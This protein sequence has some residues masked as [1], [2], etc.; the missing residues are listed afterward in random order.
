VLVS[1]LGRPEFTGMGGMGRQ[2]S[3]GLFRRA[4]DYAPEG[5]GLQGVPIPVWSTKAFTAS[6]ETPLGQLPFEANL[7]YTPAEQ[8]QFTG[9]IQSNL[10][11]PLQDAWVFYGGQWY[12]LGAE[13]PRKTPGDKPPP[14]RI[15]SG[16]NRGGRKL[17]T[18]VTTVGQD[19][20]A[21]EANVP[22]QRSYDAT[23][24]VKA[25]LF[26]QSTDNPGQ[27]RNHSFRRLDQSWRLSSER[28][29]HRPGVTREAIL[30]ARLPRSAG[31]ADPA[32]RPSAAP[33]L[34]LG[35]LPG[36]GRTRP[37]L[38]GSLIQDTYLRVYLPVTPAQP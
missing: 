18:W 31:Q 21:P 2:R 3:Q 27:D 15:A 10:P 5:A 28:W 6:W 20:D 4:Y 19:R 16:P 37:E 1:W 22:S 32:G 35:E 29:G 30:F 26:Q 23:A 11:V 25:L 9:S 38:S 7:H 8:E 36:E 33:A 24:T 12:P 14:W 17:D 13:G 34:W